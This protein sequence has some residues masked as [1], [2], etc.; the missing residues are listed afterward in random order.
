LKAAVGDN[1]LVIGTDFDMSQGNTAVT[2]SP[3]IAVSP[4][5][6]GPTRLIVTVP[7]GAVSGPVKVKTTGGGTAASPDS[8]VVLPSITNILPSSG[9]PG[10]RVG[11]SGYNFG[12]DNSLIQVRFH[13][14]NGAEI[15]T[16]QEVVATPFMLHVMVPEKAQTGPVTVKVGSETARYP[17]DF[18]VPAVNLPEIEA[19]SPQRGK[20]GTKVT[21]KGKNLISKDGTR[22]TVIFANGTEVPAFRK[23]PKNTNG[24]EELVFFVPDNAS[25]GRISVRTDRLI[26]QSMNPFTVSEFEYAMHL[27]E[28]TT[29]NF[30][31]SDNT[32]DT[33][34]KFFQS[35]GLVGA[36]KIPWEYGLV[37]SGL[38]LTYRGVAVDNAID[39]S[40]QVVGT[41]RMAS[42]KSIGMFVNTGLMWPVLPS[43][44]GLGPSIAGGFE[45][46]TD[47]NFKRDAQLSYGIYLKMQDN[48][49][50]LFFG[51]AGYG[52][53]DYLS[54]NRFL[55]DI[56]I[57]LLSSLL[58]GFGTPTDYTNFY[59]T[60]FSDIYFYSSLS[61]GLGGGP[62]DDV[63]SFG[64]KFIVSGSKLAD[65][66]GAIL[67]PT[68]KEEE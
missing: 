34:G 8:L 25:T 21:I 17:V 58:N 63:Y 15:A 2:F 1:V 10:T 28:G 12:R 44:I 32:S 60:N 62:K 49:N 19:F 23:K 61:K 14:D 48:T 16:A 24:T 43:T 42:A 40:P 50:P 46:L 45:F 6:I 53:T 30:W 7:E 35:F 27:F 59:D 33:S 29:V 36:N 56:S 38:E 37:I 18:T 54:S 66:L 55:L 67:I 31:G 64:L 13:N 41:Q 11:I 26:G 47:D 5:M 4:R 20:S 51:Q 57:P 3:D 52:H 9:E 22:Q 68:A 39:G 65:N